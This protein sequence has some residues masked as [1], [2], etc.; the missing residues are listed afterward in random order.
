MILVYIGTTAA[1]FVIVW[2]ILRSEARKDPAVHVCEFDVE[3][4]VYADRNGV[5]YTKCIHGCGR[6]CFTNE[7][8]IF[9][10]KSHEQK[11]SL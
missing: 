11:K 9:G 7:M 3:A 1:Y 4:D 6:R 2:Y 10:E 8:N 5:L